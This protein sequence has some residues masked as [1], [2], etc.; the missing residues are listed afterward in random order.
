MA[1]TALAYAVCDPF[2]EFAANAHEVMQQWLEN[3][4]PTFPTRPPRRTSPV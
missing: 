2:D 1:A 4:R 3:L